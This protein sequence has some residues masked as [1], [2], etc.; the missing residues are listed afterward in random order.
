MFLTGFAA[1]AVMPLL[2]VAARDLDGVGLYPLVAGAFVAASLLGG[3][4]GGAWADRG[5][6]RQPLT[7]GVILTVATLL[8]S[9][10]S[11]TIWQLALGRFTDGIA[12]GMVAVSIN[13]AIGQ[14]YPDR[15]RARA[16][17]LMSACWI[18]PS[19]AGP[20]LAGLVAAS[21]SWRVVFFGV[22]AFTLVPAVAAV[23]LLRGQPAQRGGKGGVSEEPGEGDA[24][25]RRPALAATVVVCVAAALTQYG[26][27]AWNAWHAVC[28]STG[29]V[30]LVACG[31]KLLPRHTWRAGS[32]L[33][34]TVLLRALTSGAFFTLEAFVPLML[35]TARHVPGVVT[36]LAFTG[37][38]LAWAGA[39]W[40]QGR[41]QNRVARH[42][43]VA[44]GASIMAVA[45]AVAAL[46]T[47]SAV[48][49]AVAV[50]SMA[51]AAVG[52][53]L[54][55]P[56]LTLLS[57]A[58]S[59]ADRQGYASG[60]MQ[61][62]QSLG[63]TLVLAVTSALFTA[64]SAAWASRLPAFAG[65]YA[66]LILPI[67]G[68][69]FL[70]GRTRVADT[71]PR[72]ALT[73]SVASGEGQPQRPLPPT[74]HR[75]ALLVIDMQCDIRPIMHR[76]ETTVATIARLSARARAANIPVITVQQQGCGDVLP[77]LAPHSG[78]PVVTKTCADA[79]LDTG[80][81]ETLAR[82]GVTEL[83]VTGFATENCVETTARRALS[84]G[85]DL[86]L[87]ADGHTT[88]VRS[89]PTDFAPPDQA[90]AH[91]NEIYRHIDFP[92]RS[93]RVLPSAEVDFMASPL[94]RPLSHTSVP[95]A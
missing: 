38:A 22:A 94:E 11:T 68:A 86:V 6:A 19:L 93:V 20:P 92:E 79:F 60:A 95:D 88:S 71:G 50:S 54:A 24:S 70:A 67:A 87:V 81:D 32:G 25:V 43:L 80:L 4:L 23:L 40:M 56:S 41:L 77:R 47:V 45:V 52:M 44:I 9:A 16:L 74:P 15:L 78:E 18:V 64:L 63:Q 29:L 91:H 39:S 35:S 2:P 26:V 28:A 72:E 10:T 1:L 46:C 48:P 27:S 42:R 65:A 58:H 83:L 36:G 49:P 7:A 53:G 5:G 13:A 57:L 89:Q 12:A 76:P 3:V 55:A 51:I 17:S 69:A 8:V 73:P 59:P 85:Y 75:A 61:T 82:L 14:S 30:L 66:L 34:A 33:P 21:W 84:H 90:I 37:A 62:A 31:P